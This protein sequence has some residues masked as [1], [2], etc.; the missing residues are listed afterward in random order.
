MSIRRCDWCGGPM[1]GRRDAVT[2]SQRCRQARHRFHRDAEHRDPETGA[3]GRPMRWGY[4]DPPYPG[5]A[6]MYEGH[7][8]YAGELPV[9]EVLDE[10]AGLELDGWAMSTSAA[11]L[12]HAL[13]LCVARALEV[14]VAVWHRHV[15]DRS[16]AR[17]PLNAWEPI[18]WHGGRQL[19]PVRSDHL[20]YA[21]RPRLTDPNRVVGAKPAR[22]ARFVFELLGAE[23]GDELVDLYPGSGGIGRAWLVFTGANRLPG[24]DATAPSLFDEVGA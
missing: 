4:A 3:P 15:R 2:C 1:V 8:D 7:R 5:K 9:D 16:H 14:R 12:P 10:L 13:A 22:F 24:R 21:A 20:D 18:I 11:A 23:P 6:H 17:G 19:G